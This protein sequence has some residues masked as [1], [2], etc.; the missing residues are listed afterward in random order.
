MRP[1][2]R[3]AWPQS[4]A[5]AVRDHHVY[6]QEEELTQGELFASARWTL[7]DAQAMY[8]PYLVGAQV[9]SSYERN[10]QR[11]RLLRLAQ[12]Q[13]AGVPSGN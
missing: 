10:G 11:F 2:S 13:V 1:S 3:S 7:P 6:L 9:V 4:L 5:T 12:P 8:A